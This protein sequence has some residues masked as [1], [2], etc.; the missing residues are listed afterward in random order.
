MSRTSTTVLRLSRTLLR[1]LIVLNA[2]AGVILVFAFLAS[3][4]FEDTVA[5]YYQVRAM[6]AGILIPTLR[7]WMVVA[8]PYFVVVHMMLSRLFDVV[9]TVRAG[10]PFIPENAERLTA[11]AWYLLVLQLLHLVFGLMASIAEAANADVDWSFS[12]G[13]WLA[14]V[15]MFVVARVFEEGTRIRDDLEAMI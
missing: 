12:I 8:A 10:R 9:D 11:I 6:D 13:G 1:T 7:I 2:A 4:I 14:V 3:F 15:L 5:S